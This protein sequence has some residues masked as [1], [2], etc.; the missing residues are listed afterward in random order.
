M[1]NKPKLTKAQY[2]EALA[3]MRARPGRTVDRQHNA[4]VKSFDTWKAHP[5]RYD[6]YGVD[7][8]KKPRSTSGPKKAVAKKGKKTAT[9]RKPSKAQ[10]AA[11]AA[12]RAKMVAN[13]IKATPRAKKEKQ[14]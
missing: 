2:M 8:K 3:I 5:E 9:K 11:L 6:L 13:A 14:D 1:P 12:G 7:R 10:L 4:K